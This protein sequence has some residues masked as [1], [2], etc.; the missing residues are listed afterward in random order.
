MTKAYISMAGNAVAVPLMALCCL[1]QNFWLALIA[2][3][4]KVLVSGLWNSPNL[5]MLQNT[6]KNS[7]QGKTLSAYFFYN[8]IASTISPIVFNKV[9]IA[10]NCAS[11]PTLYGPILTLFCLIGYGGSVPFFWKA[12]KEYKK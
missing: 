2:L 6:V 9:A 3:A 12:G 4:A 7:N 11:N 1:Q 10:F 5:T 8:T